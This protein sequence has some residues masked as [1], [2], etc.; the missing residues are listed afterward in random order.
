MSTD[1][2]QM[3]RGTCYQSSRLLADLHPEL[4]YAEGHLIIRVG[5]AE[6][7]I[8]HAWNVHRE[9]GQIVDSTRD[10]RYDTAVY[11]YEEG[12]GHG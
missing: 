4:R 12:A 9:T 5:L 2:P 6:S 7:R 3:P 10:R 1:Y 8:A 11:T